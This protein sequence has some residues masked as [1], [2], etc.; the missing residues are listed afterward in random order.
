MD[1]TLRRMVL[2]DWLCDYIKS[3]KGRGPQNGPFQQY[4]RETVAARMEWT[5]Q[6]PDLVEGLLLKEKDQVSS[7]TMHAA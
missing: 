3:M 1:A 4:V 2:P 7:R 5:V 6:R